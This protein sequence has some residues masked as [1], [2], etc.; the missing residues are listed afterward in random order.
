M[1]QF[2]GIV[3]FNFWLVSLHI[4]VTESRKFLSYATQL[5]FLVKL[6]SIFT[7]TRPVCE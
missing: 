4:F 3:A 7:T 5:I 2:L 6:I 1:F